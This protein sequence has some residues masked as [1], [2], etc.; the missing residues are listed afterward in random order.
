MCSALAHTC[1]ALGSPLRAWQVITR[2]TSRGRQMLRASLSAPILPA[3]RPRVGSSAR[4]ARLGP[5]SG[6]SSGWLSELRPRASKLSPVSP[7]TRSTACPQ[8]CLQM[9]PHNPPP[10][11]KGPFPQPCRRLSSA[12]PTHRSSSRSFCSPSS[13]TLGLSR[14]QSSLSRSACFLGSPV[15]CSLWI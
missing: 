12:F 7:R 13:P 14:S 9:A 6:K 5:V 4:E 15:A 2:L 10:A 1:C 8:P 3:L 11:Q